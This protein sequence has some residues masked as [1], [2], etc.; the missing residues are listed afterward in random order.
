MRTNHN[1]ARQQSDTPLKGVRNYHSAP[2]WEVQNRKKLYR[3]SLYFIHHH[4]L[5]AWL[6]YYNPNLTHNP[7]YKEQQQHDIYIQY[8]YSHLQQISN[9]PQQDI[10]RTSLVRKQ[11]WT[12]PTL[13]LSE[14]WGCREYMTTFTRVGSHFLF[15]ISRSC[16][17]TWVSPS[18]KS[19]ASKMRSHKRNWTICFWLSENMEFVSRTTSLSLHT[20]IHTKYQ[21][22]LKSMF[23]DF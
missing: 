15:I 5:N 12:S 14:V 16:V 7:T 6:L 18:G 8:N 13:F 23:S 4:S 21:T 3:N 11:F 17:T 10:N 19:T 1:R 9:I 22:V 2:L 20:H